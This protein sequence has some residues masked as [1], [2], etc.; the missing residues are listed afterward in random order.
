M[1]GLAERA[2]LGKGTF[3]QGS[4]RTQMRKTRCRSST[5]TAPSTAPACPTCSR[6]TATPPTGTTIQYKISASWN[7]GKPLSTF[8]A[9]DFDADGVPDLW[10]VTP[11]GIARAYRISDLSTTSTARVKAGKPQK[12]S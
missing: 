8:E 4:S 7:K 12:L 10:T 9:A 11:S 1:D 3:C 2:G 6:S 5:P